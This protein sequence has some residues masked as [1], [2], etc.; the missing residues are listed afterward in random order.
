MDQFQSRDPPKL[1]LRAFRAELNRLGFVRLQNVPDSDCCVF[2]R[3][4]DRAKAQTYDSAEATG[5]AALMAH[6]PRVM[7]V[8]RIVH[9]V[10]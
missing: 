3:C 2:G 8:S 10:R 6:L 1:R 7:A 5:I 4:A 9:H